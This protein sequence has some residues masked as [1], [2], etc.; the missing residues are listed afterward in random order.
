MPNDNRIS[1]TVTDAVVTEILGHIGAIHSA[2]AFLVNLTP[3][4]RKSLLAIGTARA[5]MDTDFV[6]AMNAHPELVPSYVT[7]AE[8]LKDKEFR[9]Q[10]GRIIGPISELNEALI[11]T[12]ALAAHD[13][14]MAYLSFYANTK[15]A[16]KRNVPGADTLVAAL[17]QYFPT[18]RRNPTPSPNP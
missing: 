8:V 11:D 5:G 12:N 1:Q 9:R 4:E 3:A 14:M 17:A 6:N 18:G 13:S 7:M 15:E 16:A 10:M 2:L